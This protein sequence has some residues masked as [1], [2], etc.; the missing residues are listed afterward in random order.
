MITYSSREEI[1]EQYRWDLSSIFESDE[2]FL[3]ALEEAK[4]LPPR[5]ASFQGKIS[6]SAANLL[7][8][9][10]LDDEAGLILTKLVNYAERKSDEDTRESRYQDYS[11][12]VMTLWVSLSSAS[13][14]FTSELLS[15]SEQE[16]EGF[17]S[18]EPELELYRRCLDVIF[19]RREHVLSP[20][21]EKLLAAAG[22]MANQPDNIFSLLND[23]DLTFPDAHDAEG[24]AHPVTHG[25]YIPLMMSA[26]RTLRESAS[27]S[28]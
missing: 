27:A 6:A 24:A 16:M 1:D 5:F 11:S 22:D 9:L 12:Q 26:D 21:E 8:Y 2:A 15:L 13:S 14:W 18:Q 7:A 4:K 28:L 10:K 3:A 23:A 19:S 20:A 17:Y 25:S